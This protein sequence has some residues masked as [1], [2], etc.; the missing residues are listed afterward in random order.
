MSPLSGKLR[1]TGSGHLHFV[2]EPVCTTEILSIHCRGR[3]I[4][5]IP[6][7][8]W[9]RVHLISHV[10]PSNSL[11]FSYWEGVPFRFGD[12]VFT[13]TKPKSYLISREHI[14]EQVGG[15]AGRITH[16]AQVASTMSPSVTPRLGCE[17]FT[18]VTQ[19]DILEIM[20]RVSTRG[21]VAGW[22]WTVKGKSL[23][24]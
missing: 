4:G 9:I 6:P 15:D 5:L 12:I 17:A 10:C 16:V 23:S 8:R 22:S 21:I 7:R 3:E 14:T 24:E 19:G 1:S 2:F 13:I 18:V 20:W 11:L